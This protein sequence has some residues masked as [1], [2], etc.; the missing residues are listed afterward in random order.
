MLLCIVI[1]III[2][3]MIIFLLLSLASSYPNA[4]PYGR[5]P[6]WCLCM[7]SSSKALLHTLLLGLKFHRKPILQLVA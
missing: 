3:I 5:N 6:V 4:S 2:V 1:V 7:L